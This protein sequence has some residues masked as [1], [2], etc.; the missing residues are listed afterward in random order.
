MNTTEKGELRRG[1]VHAIV[2]AMRYAIALAAVLGLATLGAARAGGPEEQYLGICNLIREADLL[3]PAARANEALP[4]YHE[5]KD[6]LQR[7]QKD[8]PNWNAEIVG[9]RLGYLTN[10]IANLSNLP[11][12]PA[13]PAAKT[14]AAAPALAVDWEVQLVAL[15]EQVRQ[16]QADKELLQA[17]LKEA[18]GV[19]P[20]TADPREL[21]RLE[22]R[23]S[24]LQRENALLAATVT[25]LKARLL[26]SAVFSPIE[27]LPATTN[28]EVLLKNE[29]AKV[30]ALEKAGPSTN[31]PGSRPGKVIRITPDVSAPRPPG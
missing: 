2:R 6:A 13:P 19:M 21:A 4:R 24:A 3:L 11:A 23:V 26:A 15:Q 5:A 28:M 25:D 8:F 1:P 17:K 30:Q 20:A 27:V 12:N 29:R 31:R 16:L 9:F 14:A 10:R 18:L 22:A 7:L